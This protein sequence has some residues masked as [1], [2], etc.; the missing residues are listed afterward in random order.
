M[1]E[2]LLTDDAPERSKEIAAL[3]RDMGVSVTA[4]D[5]YP[6]T[7]LS[8]FDCMLALD[9]YVLPRLSAEVSWMKMKLNVTVKPRI[10]LSK[11]SASRVWVS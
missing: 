7:P 6:D 2:V 5:H 3:L 9:T 11:V 8:S 1:I 4:V 10:M